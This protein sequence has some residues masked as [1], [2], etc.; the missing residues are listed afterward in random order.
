MHWLAK[1][2]VSDKQA[3]IGQS[4]ALVV[5]LVLGN[6]SGGRARIVSVFIR[7]DILARMTDPL[8]EGGTKMVTNTLTRYG[9]YQ[10]CWLLMVVNE[11]SLLKFARV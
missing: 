7:R 5:E 4:K 1:A 2:G 11:M 6:H 10:N 8:E 9:L 3:T